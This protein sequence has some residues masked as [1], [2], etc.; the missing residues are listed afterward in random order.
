MVELFE[1]TGLAEKT[2]AL[3][4]HKNKK[5]EKRAKAVTNAFTTLSNELELRSD[6]AAIAGID[7]KASLLEPF[8]VPTPRAS[9]DASQ[10]ASLK[11]SA[12]ETDTAYGSLGNDLPLLS[13]E[14]MNAKVDFTKCASGLA[15]SSAPL[16]PTAPLSSASS[17]LPQPQPQFV[18]T[19]IPVFPPVESL[20][21]A[22]SCSNGFVYNSVSSASLNNANHFGAAVNQTVFDSTNWSIASP[23]NSTNS[24]VTNGQIYPLQPP[25]GPINIEIGAPG[26]LSP[27]AVGLISPLPSCLADTPLS[28]PSSRHESVES[29][30]TSPTGVLAETADAVAARLLAPRTPSPPHAD[31]ALASVDLVSHCTKFYC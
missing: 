31:V 18:V 25:I 29:D 13:A 2:E 22:A 1:S 19:N 15:L 8:V 7:P 26:A 5:L 24:F 20:S 27:L 11:Q 14:L 23:P 6:L 4:D 28:M 30:P 17:C 10:S 21:T 3:L 9:Q 12:A 16:W